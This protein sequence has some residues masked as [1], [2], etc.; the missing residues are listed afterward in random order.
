MIGSS[1]VWDLSSYDFSHFTRNKS[2]LSDEFQIS[3]IKAWLELCPK[4]CSK[5]SRSNAA[6]FLWLERPARVKWTLQSALGEPMTFERDFS[7]A[8]NEQGKPKGRGSP[9]FMPI[10]D[11]NG[12]ITIRILSIQTVG[13]KLRLQADALPTEHASDNTLTASLDFLAGRRAP[14]AVG[15]SGYNPPIRLGVREPSGRRPVREPS[16]STY[17]YGI[18]GGLSEYTESGAQASPPHPYPGS[19]F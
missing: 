1:L 6:V 12:S 14:V 2:Q 19:L 9:D 15:S 17:S 10:S 13:S 16:S 4:G 3:G 5:S 18:I 11:T 7:T 8:V